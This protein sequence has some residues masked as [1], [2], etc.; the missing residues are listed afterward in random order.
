MVILSLCGK[1]RLFNAV[2]AKV[3]AQS[4]AMM[5]HAMIDKSKRDDF[6]AFIVITAMALALCVM[7]LDMS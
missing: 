3:V 1:T 4:G 7:L 2:E 6:C 5:E